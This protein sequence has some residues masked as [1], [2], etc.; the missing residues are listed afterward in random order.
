M[1][2]FLT[3]SGGAVVGRF[4]RCGLSGGSHFGWTL[5][6]KR[7]PLLP[8]YSLKLPACDLKYELSTRSSC[9]R[10][11]P[12]AMKDSYPSEAII[13]S[14]SFFYNLPWSWCFITAIEN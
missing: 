12:P 7:L 8:G 4:R 2:M 9:C 1:K 11:L 6:F 10:C 5:G 3:G 14:N 13:P